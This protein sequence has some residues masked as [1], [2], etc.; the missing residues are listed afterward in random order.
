MCIIVAV[1]D[2]DCHIFRAQFMA[3]NIA[4]CRTVAASITAPN[5][6]AITTP[7]TPAVMASDAPTIVRGNGLKFWASTRAEDY[8]IGKNPATLLPAR[9]TGVRTNY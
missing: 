3:N 7:N 4:H 1:R 6:S 9:V 2:T 5:A 8:M